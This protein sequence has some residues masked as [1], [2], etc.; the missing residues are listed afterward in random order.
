VAMTNQ[1][2]RTRNRRALNGLLGAFV[3]GGIVQP[4]TGWKPHPV[5]SADVQTAAAP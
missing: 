4:A 2:R 5:A 1:E 3:I